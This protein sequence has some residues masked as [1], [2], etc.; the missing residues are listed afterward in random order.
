[1]KS[2]ARFSTDELVR[3]KVFNILFFSTCGGKSEDGEEEKESKDKN[4]TR[5]R[6]K[7]F[8]CTVLPSLIIAQ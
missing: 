8:L 6:R 5:R 7:F 1:M 3:D 2:C 4:K